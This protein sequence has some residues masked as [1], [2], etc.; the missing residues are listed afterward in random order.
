MPFWN[1]RGASAAEALVRLTDAS[2]QNVSA[3]KVLEVAGEPTAYVYFV[4]SGWLV[5]SKSTSDGQRH[6]VDFILPG[7]FCDPGSARITQTATDICAH[8]RA[9]LAIMRRRDWSRLLERSP[10]FQTLVNRHVAAR[11]SGMAERMLRLGK[12]NAE[13]R[14]AYAI[15]ELCLRAHDTGPLNGQKFHLPL[16]QQALGDYVGLSS[17]HVSRTF[18]RFKQH[19]LVTISDHM[20]IIIHDVD[21]FA[22]IAEVDIE[23]LRAEII[24]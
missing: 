5:S 2:I 24:A 11:C 13:T 12:A 9:E 1:L 23:A 17:V 21:E 20:D 7:Q 15:C 8:T 10:E 14:I 6:I 3:G 4:I 22:A 19:D 16:T 18:C